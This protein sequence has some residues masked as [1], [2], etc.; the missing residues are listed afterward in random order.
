MWYEAYQVI[1]RRKRGASELRSSEPSCFML[2]EGYHARGRLPPR[3]PH[4]ADDATKTGPEM[5]AV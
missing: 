2:Y 5:M 4:P 3:P 1:K